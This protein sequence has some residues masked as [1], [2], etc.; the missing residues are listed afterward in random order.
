MTA[1]LKKVTKS[2]F[3]LPFTVLYTK[4][5]NDIFALRKKKS[6]FC[7]YSELMFIRG[8]QSSRALCTTMSEMLA[9]CVISISW[10]FMHS[11]KWMTPQIG[12]LATLRIM[13]PLLQSQADCAARSRS[14]RINLCP[15]PKST[16]FLSSPIFPRGSS[17]QQGHILLCI[18]A[19]SVTKTATTDWHALACNLWRQQKCLDGQRATF[20][21]M[22]WKCVFKIE[23]F[24][25]FF[26]SFLFFL[27]LWCIYL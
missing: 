25:L 18:L 8:F 22:L 10:D 20:G 7:A 12:I 19:R 4:H 26:F 13:S 27:L 1:N 16:L 9:G 24:N 6:L 3:I 11:H 15:C 2:F 23:T 21:S 17:A 14:S 5:E